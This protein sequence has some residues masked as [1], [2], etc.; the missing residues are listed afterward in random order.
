MADDV[1]A[2][3]VLKEIRRDPVLKTIPVLIVT[4]RPDASREQVLA[5]GAQGVLLKPFKLAEFLHQAEK[6]LKV[7]ALKG[8]ARGAG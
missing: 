3:A 5:P 1:R 2:L 8:M 7:D 6:V 4:G